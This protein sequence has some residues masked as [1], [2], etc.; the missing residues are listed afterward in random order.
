[1]NNYIHNKIIQDQNCTL[2]IYNTTDK[3]AGGEVSL[4][5]NVSVCQS[6]IQEGGWG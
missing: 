2:A 5:L 6:P 4:L 1:M 3:A